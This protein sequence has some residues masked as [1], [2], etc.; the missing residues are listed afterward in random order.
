[1]KKVM[2]AV[3]TAAAIV[4]GAP[5][6]AQEGQ[7]KAAPVDFRACTFMEGKGMKD[8]EKVS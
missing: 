8:L 4:L 6:L 1:M 2:S 7:V 5:A 3:A